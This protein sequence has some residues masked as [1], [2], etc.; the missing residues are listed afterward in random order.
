MEI[1][2]TGG[3]GFIGRATCR[4]LAELGFRP[5]V[6]DPRGRLPMS[7]AKLRLGDIRDATAVN[8]AMAHAQG[9]IHLAG[10]LGT[11]ETINNPLPAAETNIMGGL[12]V[13]DA[14]AEY[15]LPTVV[16]GVGNW[17]EDNT[18]SLTKHC[19]ERFCGMYRKYRDLPVAVVRALN[20]YGPRQSVAT[21]YGASRVRKIT[22]SFV[23]RALHGHPIEVYGDGNQIMDMIHVDDV[24]ACLVGALQ[25]VIDGNEQGAVFEA[26]TGRPT[27]VLDIANAVLGAVEKLGIETESTIAHLPMRPGE[28]PGVVVK[29]DTSTLAPL[30]V[31][32]GVDPAKFVTLE[33]GMAETV[34]WYARQIQARTR[35]SVDLL[36]STPAGA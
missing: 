12:T 26:G 6:L 19:V 21:P 25:F 18:Y 36:G 33:D 31:P 32:Y 11:Q 15:N 10:V 17:F 16:I 2:V 34:A 8:E 13:L 28:T 29:A 27:T 22:P 20:A 30:T 35:G 24:A 5:T 3:N 23:M 9:V 1:L 7:G 14:A 4:R